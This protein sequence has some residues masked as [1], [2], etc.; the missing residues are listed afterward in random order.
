MV[1]LMVN[2]KISEIFGNPKYEILDFR[3][4]FNIWIP[5]FN[6]FLAL[7]LLSENRVTRPLSQ[8]GK[9]EREE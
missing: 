9:I 1:F 4:N 6:D 5:H 7:S 2:Q 8:I 3:K